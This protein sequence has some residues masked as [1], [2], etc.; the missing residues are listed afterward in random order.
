MSAGSEMMSLTKRL[1]RGCFLPW[2]GAVLAA[3]ALSACSGNEQASTLKLDTKASYRFDGW[4]TSLAWWANV[5]GSGG[6]NASGWQPGEDG[7][8]LDALF[9]DPDHVGTGFAQQPVRPLGLNV[10]RYNIGASPVGALADATPPLPSDCRGFHAGGAVPSPVQAAGGPVDLTND[11]RQVD[12]LL[13]AKKL[14]D[15]SDGPGESTI[16]EAFA[17]APP[18]WLTDDHCPA[19]TK[20]TTPF[21]S[22]PEAVREYARYLVNVAA[23]FHDQGVDF[24]T[25]E[26]FNEPNDSWWGG[27]RGTSGC[28]EGANFP[29]DAQRDVVDALCSE[30]RN[31]QHPGLAARISANDENDPDKLGKSMPAWRDNGCLA[32]VNVHGYS[33]LQPYSGGNRAKVR[34]AVG[35]KP[36][37]MSE[38]GTGPCSDKGGAADACAG[39]VLSDQ[40]ADDLQDLRPRVW[41]YWQAVEAAGGWGL[42]QD[43][44]FPSPPERNGDL[45]PTP[46]F[47]ALAQY[48]HYV[49]GGSTIYPLDRPA[50]ELKPDDDTPRVVV[51]RAATGQVDVVATNPADREQQLSLSLSPLAGHGSAAPERVSLNSAQ[52]IFATPESIQLKDA[53]L[54]DAL[55]PASITTYL[56]G[57]SS[58]TAPTARPCATPGVAGEGVFALTAAGVSCEFALHFAERSKLCSLRDPTS[59]ARCTDQGWTCAVGPAVRAHSGGILARCTRNEDRIAWQAGF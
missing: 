41:V 55:P 54:T 19:G 24:A 59:S 57:S 37:W 10:L 46:R 33:G 15:A 20:D 22:H 2:G 17:N 31:G 56:I 21:A 48:S 9:G 30:L 36:L 47:W 43:L 42:L 49:R 4:G 58:A 34:D 6:R 44:H 14:I 16:L 39:I 11:T 35:D 18:W 8:V 23:A 40:I 38:F 12:V 25:I 51:A 13:Q 7:Q 52:P 53:I 29:P 32:H 27:C 1:R 3:V 26:P 28:Q 5:V 50:D 45:Y